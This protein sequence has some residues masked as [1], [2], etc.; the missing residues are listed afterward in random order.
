MKHILEQKVYFADTDKYAVVW[1][2]T[3]LRWMEMGRV[4]FCEMTGKTINDLDKDDILVPVTNIN[5]KFKSSAKLEDI[6]LIETEIAKFN[7][8]CVTFHQTIKS[9]KTGQ[10]YTDAL[11]DVVAVN[12]EG[13]LYRKMPSVLA[14]LFNEALKCPQPV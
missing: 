4:E 1:H 10:I 9:K 5:I 11:V 7:G 14:D 12:H 8:F 6:I 2:G 3:Y 13:K